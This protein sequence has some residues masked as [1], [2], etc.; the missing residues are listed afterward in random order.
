MTTAGVRVMSE[1]AAQRAPGPMTQQTTTELVHAALHGDRDAWEAI[2]DRYDR[3]VWSVVRSF[4]LGDASSA[5]V[6]QTVWLR[7]VENLDRI[8]EPERLPAWLAATARNEALR[9]LR[10]A[11]RAVPTELDDDV[12]DDSIEDVAETLIRDERLAQL[13]GAYRQIS[14]DCQRL[15]RLLATDPPLDYDTIA[16]IIGRPKGS[17]G[18][19]R[20]RCIAKLNRILEG[21]AERDG[22]RPGETTKGGAR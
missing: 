11:R 21:R 8:R 19:T 22:E 18:P 13:A 7:L 4:R 20:A 5:D 15:L 12:A 10:T 6:S 16:D 14:E 2:V 17:I 9:T 1:F 3:L